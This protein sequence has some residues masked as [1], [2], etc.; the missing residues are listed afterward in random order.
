[1][2]LEEL[3]AR[4][5]RLA[6]SAERHGRVIEVDYLGKL[7]KPAWL[8]V[9]LP[10]GPD[11]ERVKA[12]VNALAL[13]TVCKEAAC[14]NMAECWGAGTATIMILGDTVHARLPLLQ[15]EDR[16]PAR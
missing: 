6:S 3:V 10:S 1:M 14:P 12:R 4:V 9:S 5:R 11:Y 7:R 16:Q 15:R 2:L 8:R 13:N